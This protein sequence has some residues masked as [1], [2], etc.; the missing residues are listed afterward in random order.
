MNS[1]TDTDKAIRAEYV[2]LGDLFMGFL[3]MGLCGF[4]GVAAWAHRIV[5]EERRWL[6]DREFADLLSL[7]S[8]L[9]GPNIVNVSV[10][11]GDRFQGAIGSV[12]ALSG[13]MAAPL[14]ILLGMATL[15]DRYGGLP[16]VQAA[17]DGVAAAAAG[18][19]IGTALKMGRRLRPT[20]VAILIGC[21]AFLGA[22]LLQWPLVWVVIG[23]A[24]ASVILT[25]WESRR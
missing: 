10:M 24:P 21:L 17:I 3:K 14:A 18:L 1:S 8:V 7:G 23:L 5:V 2:S 16:L 6:N 19:V 25:V 15:Y 12:A 13:L 22:G 4:G 11:V 9:P 20:R